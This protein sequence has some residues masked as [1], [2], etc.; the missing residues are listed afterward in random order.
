MICWIK[1]GFQ[2]S[3][4]IM[5]IPFN[6]AFTLLQHMT[7]CTCMTELWILLVLDYNTNS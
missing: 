2:Y 3:D 7:T 6:I 1:L 5:L 4:G